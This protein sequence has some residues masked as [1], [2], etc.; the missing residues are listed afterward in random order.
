M[1]TRKRPACIIG[2]IAAMTSALSAF[3]QFPAVFRL[4]HLDGRNGFVANGVHELDASG[5]VVSGCGDVNRDGLDDLVIGA[6]GP[7]SVGP[8]DPRPP[9]YGYVVFGRASPRPSGFL[10]LRDLD[11]SDGFFMPGLAPLDNLGYGAAGLGDVNKDGVDDLT[12]GAPLADPNGQ[13]SAGLA[14]VFFGRQGMGASGRILPSTL[15][16]RNGFTLVGAAMGDGAGEAACPAGD[17]NDDG[18]PDFAVAAPWADPPGRLGAGQ[19]YVIFGGP[20]ISGPAVR[21]FAD[22]DGTNGFAING[23]QPGDFIGLSVNSAGDLN[24]DGIDDLGIGARWA[25][26]GV[27][28]GQGFVIF[29]VPGVGAGGVFELSDLDGTNGFVINGVA[30]WE[31]HASSLAG[32]GDINDDGIDDLGVAPNR[33]QQA[34]VILGATDVGSSGVIELSSLDGRQG[35]AL[36]IADWNTEGVFCPPIDLNAD[37]LADLI[38]ANPHAYD[39]SISVVGKTYVLYGRPGL[40]GEGL[41]DIRKVNGRDGFTLVGRDLGERAGR[42]GAAGDL[43]GD[44]LDDLAI[45][46]PRASPNNVFSAGRTYIVFG[47]RLGDLD[48]DADVDVADFLLFQRCFAGEGRP[49]APECSGDVVFDLDYDGDVDLADFLI[50]QQ[51]FTGSF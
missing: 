29:G 28:T 43:N 33:A 51:H 12:L 13:Y 48:L 10:E 3:G 1:P 45:G 20:T 27:R 9:G 15:D 40:G 14:Y 42:L 44:G 23:I 32:L 47:R 49:T 2:L 36:R 5:V 46:A 8:G 24:A 35:F 31:E 6:P 34:Y 38:V 16:G 4:K 22:L 26:I 41:I 37:G 11:G 25:P 18:Y 39:G 30:P 50:F 17:L 19:V 7:R 21:S